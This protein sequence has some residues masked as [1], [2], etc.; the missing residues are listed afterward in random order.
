MEWR[1]PNSAGWIV[2]LL[3]IVP[4][5]SLG[6]TTGELSFPIMPVPGIAPIYWAGTIQALLGIGLVP[7]T[8][9]SCP[10]LLSESYLWM[11]D[12]AKPKINVGKI[13]TAVSHD[14]MP[15]TAVRKEFSLRVSG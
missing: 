11:P 6:T 10:P 4:V 12:V 3:S 15:G 2:L 13:Y 1:A 9:P 5:K 14:T 7:C 8:V